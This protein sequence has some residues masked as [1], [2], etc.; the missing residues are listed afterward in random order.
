MKNIYKKI[1]EECS[2]QGVELYLDG[3]KLKYK[4]MSGKLDE[5]VLMELKLNKAGIVEYIKEIQN[6]YDDRDNYA[7]FPLSPVQTSY[8]FGRGD[9]HSYGNVSCHIYQ[10]F[11]YEDLNVLKVQEVWN[12]LIRKH[13]MLRAVIF[14]EGF[15][16]VLETVPQHEIITGDRIAIREH[17]ENKIYQLEKWPMFDIGISKYNGK[18]ILH[19][20]MD[21]MICDWSSIW[22]LLLEFEMRY[23]NEIEAERQSKISFRNYMIN[24]VKTKEKLEY[25]KAKMYWNQKIKE[26]KTAPVLPLKTIKEKEGYRFKRMSL[27]LNQNM[28]NKF[29]NLSQKYGLTPTASVL[30]VYSEVL[31]KWSS[32]KEFLINLTLFNKK[33]WGENV[34]YL[35]GDFTNTSIILI[36]N[37]MESFV[38]QARKVNEELF[39]CIDNSLYSGVDILRDISKLNNSKD[40]LVP[41][42]FTS[43][44][45]LINDSLVGKYVYGISQTPQVFI[46][47]QAMDTDLGLQIN[48]DIREGIFEDDMLQDMFS[49]F[50]KI[51][52][53]LSNNEDRWEKKLEVDIPEWQ[54]E[55]RKKAN[56]TNRIFDNK[57]L[58]ED[59]MEKVK[60]Y[61]D[62]TAVI[63]SMGGMSY[64]EL[65]DK[66]VSIAL[67]LK[68]NN[69]KKGEHVIVQLPHS[70]S[71]VY[72]ILGILMVGAIY[73]P[74]D[75]NIGEKRFE[76][77]LEQC[78]CK[79]ILTNGRGNNTEHEIFVNINDVICRSDLIDMFDVEHIDSTDVAYIIFTSGTTGV[80]KGVVISHSAALNTIYDINQKFGVS[81]KDCLLG[82]SKLNFD[83]SVYDIFGMLSVGGTIVYPDESEYLNPSHWDELV[84]RNS[85][86]VWNTVPAL[87]E[88]YLS[89]LESIS[90]E[91]NS[92]GLIL[93]SG[94]WIPL[95][96]PDAL[97]KSFIRSKIIVLGGATEASIWSNYHEYKGLEKGW[98]SIP[99][100]KPLSNQQFFVLDDN[101]EDC[102]AYCEGNLYIAGKG[103]A[104]GYLGDKKLTEEKFFI[105]PQKQI[106]IYSTGD[107]GRYL[108]N[109]EIEFL[110]RKDNQVKIRGHRIELGEIKNAL[111][112]QQGIDDLI[113]RVNYDK[114]DMPIEVIAK[115]EADNNIIDEQKDKYFGGFEAIEES[116]NKE[117]DFERYQH[118]CKQRDIVCL[119][120]MLNVLIDL[121]ALKGID[122]KLYMYDKGLSNI[123]LKYHEISDKWINQLKTNSIIYPEGDF[124][125]V[126]EIINKESL[127]KI[128]NDCILMWDNKFGDINIMHYIKENIENLNEIL[129]NKVDPRGILY[130][131]GSKKYTEALYEKSIF[132]VLINGYYCKFLE[133][134]LKDNKK[135]KLRILEIGAGTGATTKK[136]L[137]I[138]DGND[139]EYHFTDLQKYFLP[140]SKEIFK[141]NR[142]ILVYQLDINED[143]LEKGLQSNYFDIIIGAYVLENVKDIAKSMSYINTLL[144]P[145]GHLLFSEPIRNEP[146]LLVSQAL[147]MEE[148][149]DSI[150]KETVFIDPAAWKNILLA[151]DDSDKPYNFPN[152]NNSLGILGANIFIKQFKKNL[153]KI[154]REKIYEDIKE[155]LPKYMLPSKIYYVESM[156]LTS[157]GKIDLK[158]NF[159]IINFGNEK[160]LIN[161]IGN[162]VVS[163]TEKEIIKI[164]EKLLEAES[165]KMDSNFYDFGADSLIIAKIAT[166]V[167][168]KLNKAISFEALLREIINNPCV[169][170]ISAFIK[171][172][173][174]EVIEKASAVEEIVYT[175]RYKTLNGMADV[176]KLRVL[177]HGAFGSW[178][179]F[180]CLATELC[181]QN[182]GDVL[183]LGVS[184]TEKYL[185]FDIK[186]LVPVL[187][188]MYCKKI[189]ELNAKEVQ[190][191]GYSFSGVVALEVARRLLELGINVVNLSI[192][193]GGTIPE[194]SFD[195]L[196]LELI[197]I[198]AFDVNLEDLGIGKI[199]IFDNIY[200]SMDIDKNILTTSN[201]L[202][203]LNTEDDL[204]IITELNNMSQ[205]DRFRKYHSIIDKKLKQTLS[206]NSLFELY[207]VFK[208]S[209]EAQKYNPD[210]FFGDIDYYIAKDNRGAYKYIELLVDKWKDLVI[211]DI[212]KIYIDGDHYSC[213]QNKENA[214]QLAMLIKK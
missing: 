34:E 143:P 133:N 91:Q 150:R 188:D 176:S 47:C 205:Q 43:A 3:E 178:E 203:Q 128:W 65:Y 181:Q 22:Q 166:E 75:V 30:T 153:M 115:I 148:P 99:Y 32:E 58:L 106:R 2:K 51:L 104:D 21:F 46:D 197:F 151:I 134:Y 73:V 15:Q 185:E 182:A 209:I 149:T 140:H 116:L 121:G 146:W 158:N 56:N 24:E 5:D 61:P 179:N 87:M 173:S 111:M 94:D 201:L 33:N 195:E 68:E 164:C 163:E 44:I 95:N 202:N 162:D 141:D 6:E 83:L 103:L 180:D 167:K 96:M 132:S 174:D 125:I 152:E 122:S 105:H 138:L 170:G 1:V 79:V 155:Y 130:P 211:G 191:I 16:K 165:L 28:W 35:I 110:G 84:E 142:N 102:P 175:K 25:K 114:D 20:S 117:I 8:L 27:I 62:K 156:V 72:S 214:K 139:Y 159:N 18:S 86:T 31:K 80:P 113:V 89:Y 88:L 10:E 81:E 93:L 160:E 37:V 196:P 42:V 199:D 77:I 210:L 55:S 100:G 108:L 204:N 48:W 154:D 189:V 131:N 9:L 82:I 60:S 85:V 57:T 39:N 69:V 107:L 66:S 177:V 194:N 136:I 200:A 144:A 126:P 119:F 12:Y 124:Y 213:V 118:I 97:Q 186:S 98:T 41:Y 78:D 183:I 26:L 184:N 101:L 212:N 54:S 40:F 29:K 172:N 187:A 206:I 38:G 49:V 190:L 127:D 17:L 71:Q 23:F 36:K 4:S 11:L 147:M 63:D 208:H 135:K 120:S 70:K 59:F 13:D 74:V 207:K 64:K 192:I 67:M 14:Q 7:P 45:G 168:K 193:E 90:K 50:E 19:F 123:D 198:Y 53:D 137:E 169:S 92:I 76:S 109:G 129:K 145:K 112:Q 171:E 157:N 52:I 161:K